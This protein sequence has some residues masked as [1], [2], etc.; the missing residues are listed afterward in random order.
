[1]GYDQEPEFY[2]SHSLQM[3]TK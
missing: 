2:S 1:M 3:A